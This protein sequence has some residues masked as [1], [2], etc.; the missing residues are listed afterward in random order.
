MLTPGDVAETL[1]WI[2]TQPNHVQIDDVGI[3]NAVNPW[4][5]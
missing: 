2:L 3:H 5:A 1:L 4:N